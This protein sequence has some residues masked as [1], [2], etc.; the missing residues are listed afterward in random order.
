MHFN[1]MKYLTKCY[2]HVK[3]KVENKALQ[4]SKFELINI[5][6]MSGE[7]SFLSFAY[8]PLN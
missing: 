8:A 4:C 3:H 7:N 2:S 6:V 1:S 5:V